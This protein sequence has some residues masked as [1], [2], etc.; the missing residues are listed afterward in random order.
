MYQAISLLYIPDLRNAFTS[1]AVCFHTEMINTMFV[2]KYHF[3]LM[4]YNWV[5]SNNKFGHHGYKLNK[6]SACA[7]TQK[8]IYIIL[9]N[10]KD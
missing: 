2:S 10:I 7:P 6:Y 9:E 3:N 8:G 5:N 1:K 4:A